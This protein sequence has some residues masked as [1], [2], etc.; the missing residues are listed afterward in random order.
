MSNQQ[1][2]DF[3]AG[4]CPQGETRVK[5]VAR[6]DDLSAGQRDQG[7]QPVPEPVKEFRAGTDWQCLKQRNLLPASVAESGHPLDGQ[8]VDALAAEKQARESVLR[9]LRVEL[10]CVLP[11]S[12]NETQAIYSTGSESI[13]GDVAPWRFATRRN[14]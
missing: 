11:G 5:D 14:H 3:L 2:F 4:Y 1:T 8:G 12:E 9:K 7:S 6:V 13:D 10:G